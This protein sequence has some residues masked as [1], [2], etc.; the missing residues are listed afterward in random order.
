MT[1]AASVLAAGDGLQGY[2]C[3]LRMTCAR[4]AQLNLRM[5]TSQVGIFPEKSPD[6]LWCSRTSSQGAV[7][8][9]AP[10]L[11]AGDGLQGYVCRRDLRVTLQ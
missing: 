5:V 1:G 3:H 9:A 10:V 11:A 7:S 8:G 4:F 2:V 6:C